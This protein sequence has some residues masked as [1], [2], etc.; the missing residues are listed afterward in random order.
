MKFFNKKV[1]K[2]YIVL[3]HDDFFALLTYFMHSLI[4]LI[5]T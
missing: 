2:K 4:K 3:I 1:K 5:K